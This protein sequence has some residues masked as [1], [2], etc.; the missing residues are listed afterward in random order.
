MSLEHRLN[1]H[2]YKAKLSGLSVRDFEKSPFYAINQHMKR[3][4]HKSL[5]FSNLG[6]V[7]GKYWH[8]E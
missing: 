1:L 7:I 5:M 2:N 8:S 6:C 3:G 4:A